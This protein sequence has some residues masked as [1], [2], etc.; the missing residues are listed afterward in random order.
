MNPLKSK[1]VLSLL[2]AISPLLIFAQTA[3]IKGFV[4][5]KETGD[6]C[7]FANVFIKNTQLGAATDMNGYFNINKVPAGEHKI[8]ISYVGYDTLSQQIVI[9]EGQLFSQNFYLEP[10][11]V[12][13]DE[14]LVSAERM[15][16]TTQ[17]RTS[18]TKVQPVQIKRLPSIGAEPDIAQYLQIVPGVVF[19]GDQGGQLYI[20]GGSP[21]QN[22]VLLDGMVVYNPFHSIGLFSVFDSDIIQNTDVYTGGFSAEYGGRI[23]SVMDFTMRDGN[24]KRFAGKISASPFGS[25]LLLEGPF[26]KFKPEK[27]S[28][29]YLVSAKTSYLEQTSK[30]LYG[31]I[32]DSLPFNYTDIYAKTSFNAANG[33]K[34]NLFGFNF[35]DQVN[36]GA[37]SNLNWN[38]SGLGS[39]FIIVPDGSSVMIRANLSYSNYLISLSDANNIPRSSEISGYNG[40]LDFI[41]FLGKNEFVWG[42]ETLGFK[43]DYVFQNSIGRT[44]N[45][46][47]N[48]TELAAYTRYKI[49]RGSLVFEPSFRVHYYASLSDVSLEPRLGVKY[50]LTE[51]FRIKF[52]GGFYSQ[53]LIAANSDRDVVNLFYGFLSGSEAIPNELDGEPITHKLQKSQ[54]AIAGFEYDIT[55][56]WELNVEGYYKNFSQLTNIN[57]NKLYDDT[58]ENYQ[59]PD[60]QK[61]DFI[62]EKGAAYGMDILLKYEH[63]RLYLWMVYGLGWVNRFDGIETYSPHFDRRHN[64][65]FVGTYHLGE[66]RSW[67]ISARW[68]LGSGFPFTQTQGFYEQLPL[69][70]NINTDYWQLNG[71]L[72]II[73][74]EINEGRL[75]MYHRLDI[76]V[77]KHFDLSE[78]SRL[79]ISASVTNVYNRENIFYFDRINFSRVN[80][81]PIMPSLGINLTF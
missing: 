30:Y 9:K 15:E 42:I 66:D 64:M 3:N 44:L 53:N 54:H 79:E 17:V 24:K 63:N 71:D 57:R 8:V 45:Q 52:A 65:N 13:L 22:L 11:S 47:E 67:E 80:Q 20:R 43:T 56:Y 31:Y 6:A 23:S 60:Y 41:Y 28:A 76:N 25:K 68:N 50:N 46:R 7:I 70:G 4:Y 61:K 16:R 78:H 32:A 51:V 5:D 77:K 2:I 75:P 37:L 74:G 39:N 26:I 73:Y 49:N 35:R 36:Y 18:V 14:A 62:I 29:S 34:V 81:L 33:S 27:G 38:S 59:I 10:S 58:P 55:N 21:I 19:T 12:I 69:Y 40:G 48:T 1:F 72:G